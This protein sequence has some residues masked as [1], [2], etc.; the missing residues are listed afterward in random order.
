LV[1]AAQALADAGH[2][3]VIASSASFQPQLNATG[4]RSTTAGLDWLE[5]Q[6]DLAFPEIIA[7]AQAGTAKEFMIAEVFCTR[8][9]RQ[10]ATDIVQLAET[11]RPDIVVRE[12][13]EFGG[14]IAAAALG[15]PCVLHGLGLWLNIEEFANVGGADLRTVAAEFGVTDDDLGWIDGDLYL[16]PCPTFLQA[17][18]QRPYPA[19]SQSIRPVAFDKTTGP[20]TLPSWVDHLHHDRPVI[21]IGLGTVMDRRGVILKAILDDLVEL[22]AELIV[23][24]GPGRLPNNLGPQLPHVHIEQYLPFTQLLSHCDLVVCHGGWGTVIGALTY[25][26]P[27]VCVPISADGFINAERCEATGLGRTVPGQAL[28]PGLIDRAVQT[29][30][31][32]SSYRDAAHQAL[33]QIADMPH[34]NQAA[35]AIENLS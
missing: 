6:F 14:G 7:H 18:S 22:D 13:S 34:P 12:Y 19:A 9:A 23:T 15:V 30:L 2:D 25:G 31:Q 10:M 21:Y 1:P 4:L 35:R 5:S 33:T 16:D 24:T 11:W 3:V 17:P 20:A 27:L 32:Q 8:T 28:Q 29:I 26:I